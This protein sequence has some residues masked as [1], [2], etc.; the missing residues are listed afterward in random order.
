M[1]T[2]S[3]IFAVAAAVTCTA[4]TANA[5]AP[6]SLSQAVIDSARADAHEV[7]TS[8]SKLVTEL[9]QEQKLT[10]ASVLSSM[11]PVKERYIC[12]KMAGTFDHMIP[13]G[14]SFAVLRIGQVYYARDPDQHRSTGVITDTTFKVL[15][16]LGAAV[17]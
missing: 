13:P 10:E 3:R 9:R 14:K 2:I 12:A 15:M 17:P 1:N 16:R 6:C 7:L 11:T 5:Q 8:Q 4:V